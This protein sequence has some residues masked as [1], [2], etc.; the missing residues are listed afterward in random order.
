MA[1]LVALT[2]RNPR[3]KLMG[4]LRNRDTSKL[5]SVQAGSL[6]LVQPIPDIDQCHRATVPIKLRVC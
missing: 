2:T 4:S 6:A 1:L 5:L 3:F